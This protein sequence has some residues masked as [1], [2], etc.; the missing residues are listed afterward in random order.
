[1]R[2]VPVR[3]EA[4]RAS[5][6]FFSTVAVSADPSEKVMLGRRWKTYSELFFE[7]SKL[8][9]NSGTYSVVFP[10]YPSSFS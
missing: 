10:L 6:L 1:M 5:R 2:A 9:A 4:F 3:A 7:T 8:S